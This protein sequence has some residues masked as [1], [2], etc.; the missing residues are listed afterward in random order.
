MFD[1]AAA[2]EATTPIT[3]YTDYNHLM[4]MKRLEIPMNKR[5]MRRLRVKRMHRQASPVKRQNLQGTKAERF[6]QVM[7]VASVACRKKKRKATTA[8]QKGNQ[9]L[10]IRAPWKPRPPPPR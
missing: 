1:P 10:P 9:P 5:W 8:S 3:I 4:K 6:S 7:R 2:A